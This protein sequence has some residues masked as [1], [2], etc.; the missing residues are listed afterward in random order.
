M[1]LF[2]GLVTFFT[3]VA[4]IRVDAEFIAPAETI[5]RVVLHDAFINVLA[6]KFGVQNVAIFTSHALSRSGSGTGTIA[7]VMAGG[8]GVSLILK[9]ADGTGVTGVS[10]IALV[11]LAGSVA[12]SCAIAFTLA[13]TRAHFAV[14]SHFAASFALRTIVIVLAAYFELV[15][16]EPLSEVRFVVSEC[17]P[18]FKVFFPGVMVVVALSFPAINVATYPLLDFDKSNLRRRVALALI[19]LLPSD[20]ATFKLASGSS[21]ETF[22]KGLD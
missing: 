2:T 17:P 22:L 11:A 12:L 13:L 14:G 4:T 20:V 5:L 16:A 21:F 6:T 9:K 15:N 7:S 3:P 18:L 1:T 8:T 10:G 19:F